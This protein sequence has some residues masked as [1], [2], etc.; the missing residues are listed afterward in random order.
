MIA[1]LKSLTAKREAARELTSTVDDL[2]EQI[3]EAQAR[4]AAIEAAPQDIETALAAFDRWADEAATQAVDSLPIRRLLSPESA[5]RGLDMAP[6]AR[7]SDRAPDATPIA[8]A[9]LGLIFLV[10]RDQLREVV[11]GQLQDLMGGQTG[12]TAATR[13]KKVEEAKSALLALEAGEELAI[14]ALEESGI[15]VVR[16]SDADPRILLAAEASLASLAG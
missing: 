13:A 9:A 3:A 12:L 11:S 2:R 15:E 8:N 16:R 14:R 7:P 5:G 1:L 10:A 6:L 4:I